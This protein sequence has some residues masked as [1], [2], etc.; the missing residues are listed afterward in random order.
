MA[1]DQARFHRR[2][3]RSRDLLQLPVSVDPLPNPH[4]EHFLSIRVRHVC[5]ANVPPVDRFQPVDLLLVGHV[6]LECQL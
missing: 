5:H 1:D 3:Q 6:L 2:S 4:G